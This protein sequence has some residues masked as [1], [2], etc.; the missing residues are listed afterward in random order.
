ML[1]FYLL[2]ANANSTVPLLTVSHTEWSLMVM[3]MV[4]DIST[5]FWNLP[6]SSLFHRKYTCKYQVAS[7]SPKMYLPVPQL[8]V[9][10]GPIRLLCTRASGFTSFTIPSSGCLMN[11]C[12]FDLSFKRCS[13]SV[14]CSSWQV[15]PRTCFLA[16][17]RILLLFSASCC[18]VTGLKISSRSK[19]IPLQLYYI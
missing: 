16:I 12:H 6:N 3:Y 7:S 2:G 1:R 11:G 8:C 10:S 4:L 13:Q 9:F 18:D 5:N 17:F 15:S 19:H 14:S